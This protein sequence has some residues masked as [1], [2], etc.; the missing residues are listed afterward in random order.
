MLSGFKFAI[1][2]LLIST[3]QSQALTP[4]ALEYI[5]PSQRAQLQQDFER[6]TPATLEE[7]DGKPWQCNLFGV[8]TG[9]QIQRNLKLY[10]FHGTLNRGT[11]L[12]QQYVA[13][14]S[15]F[16]GTTGDYEDEIRVKQDGTLISRLNKKSPQSSQSLTIAYAV[17]TS[18][19]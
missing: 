3:S 1:A 12:V 7:M 5:D 8:R 15:R 4:S 10:R 6:G 11:H 17:C 13:D 19:R 16:L 2:I 18:A 9:L 14:N